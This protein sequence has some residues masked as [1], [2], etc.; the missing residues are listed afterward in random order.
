MELLR[1]AIPL[2]GDTRHLQLMRYT[3]SRTI[4]KDIDRGF[5]YDEF[6]NTAHAAILPAIPTHSRL[7]GL[8]LCLP[9][10]I[11]GIPT[12]DMGAIT[13]RT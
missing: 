1:C 6:N 5:T 9:I 2:L 4:R 10:H 13:A 11:W 8:L 12:A 7:A 3:K